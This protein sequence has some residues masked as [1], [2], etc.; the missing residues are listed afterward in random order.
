MPSPF[1]RPLANAP[2]PARFPR[3]R[4]QAF[5]A[6][7]T[8]STRWPAAVVGVFLAL[9]ALSY[10]YIRDFPIRSAY[11][12][13]LPQQDPL[14]VQ[15]QSLEQESASTDVIAVLFTVVDPHR[16]GKEQVLSAAAERVIAELRVDENPDL[17][18]ASYRLG[19]GGSVPNE[20]LVFRTLSASERDRLRAIARE[21]QAGLRSFPSRSLGDALGAP[22]PAA[23]T[24]PE[25]L[26]TAIGELTKAGR[27]GLQFL[28][29]LGAVERSLAEAAVIVQAVISRPPP[30]ERGE[31]I[32]SRDKAHL[33]LQVWPTRRSFESVA[34]NRVVTHTVREA[35]RRAGLPDLGVTAGIAG[36]YVMI[37]EADDVI[38]QDMTRVTI[39]SSVAVVALVLV[40][41]ASPFLCVA[42]VLPVLISALF[43]MVWAKFA[44]GGFNLLTV[45][46]PALILGL[47]IDFS[48]HILSRFVEERSNGKRVN[49]ALVTAVR[50]KGSACLTAAVTT[51]VVFTCLLLSHSRALWEMG[52]IT[53]VGILLSLVTTLLLAPAL[54]A[55]VGRE[56]GAPR[57]H[58]IVST[59]ALRPLY[60]R[61]LRLR[62]GVVAVGV[63]LTGAVAYQASQVRFRFVSEELAPATPSK[64]VLATITREFSGEVWLGDSFRFFVDQAEG[65]APLEQALV[66]HP[67]V[68]STASVRNF[69]PQELL[70]GEFS[71]LDLPLA[72][73]KQ[74][75]G[76]L[77][78]Q[79]DLW[80]TTLGTVR[81]L[82]A[83]MSQREFVAV[84]GA[85]PD[86]AE[87]LSMGVGEL[88]GLLRSLEQV[89]VKEEQARLGNMSRALTTI[90]ELVQKIVDLPPEPVLLQGILDLLPEEVRSQY[91]T[92]SGRYVIEARL[93][94]AHRE[95]D[96]LQRFLEWAD[97]LKVERFGLPEV[98]AQLER[99]M[100]RDF[101]L[102][103]VL[104]VVIIFLLVW[105]DI[106]RP[107]EAAFAL[108]PLAMGY[109]WMLAGMNLL[110]V[111]FNFTNIV[112]SPLLIGIGV[113]SAVHLLHRIEEERRGGGDVV[114]RGAAASAVPVTVS[115]LTTMASFG[116]LLVAHTPGLRLLGTSALLGLGFTL[117]WSL[118]FLPAAA[119]LAVEKERPKE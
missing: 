63:I 110:G 73:V 108:A 15:F 64:A 53:G 89:K 113:D 116:A 78:E 6:L 71:I 66:G 98:T 102:S 97:T 39:V 46:L 35:V 106:P 100:R 47:G 33:V 17:V 2:K 61:F 94:P 30:E 81:S 72:E 25:A 105:R 31:P 111:Q 26:K 82:I 83:A 49:E 16:D 99:Y 1:V 45:F 96:N 109:V 14:V 54:V 76:E 86:L 52:T 75:L 43:T 38:R 84:L 62:P 79:L 56:R 80:D 24:D 11:L 74:G 119:A 32:L 55:V 60:R 20:L 90:G 57:R 12:D 87:A 104:A 65:I 114:V 29:T 67:L 107:L 70:G 44:V 118:T 50:A 36:S 27:D 21:V 18:S 58:P 3:R 37:V 91:Y 9:A 10:L 48:V 59:T 40:A 42:A 85:R 68:H 115:S 8:V 69:L 23:A 13:L 112:V 92:K 19:E 4:D 88:S 41:F 5:T 95:G 51:A 101:L 22:P 77:Q 93:K 103:T 7:A 28:G 34:Y 117:L